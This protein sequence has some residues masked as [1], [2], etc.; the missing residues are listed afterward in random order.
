M[1]NHP[2]AVLLWLDPAT[3]GKLAK[4]LRDAGFAGTLAGPGR[5]RSANFATTAG[6]A[7]EGL[8]VPAPI[9]EKDGAI[10]FQHFTGAFRKRIGHEP[11]ATATAAYDATMLLIRI[12][13]QAGDRPARESFPIGFSFTGASGIL[14][15]DAQGNRKTTLQLLEGRGGQFVP[16]ARGANE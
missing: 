8:I 11:D 10:A 13:R 7:T 1:A 16:A 9:L 15:F 2:D 5:L 14:T 3:A 12:L 4:S 6:G